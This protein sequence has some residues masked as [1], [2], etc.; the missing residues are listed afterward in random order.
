MNGPIRL[1]ITF[2]LVDV[3]RLPEARS[4]ERGSGDPQ[5]LRMSANRIVSWR[6]LTCAGDG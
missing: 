3:L 6:K 1:L 4:P 2:A 5:H